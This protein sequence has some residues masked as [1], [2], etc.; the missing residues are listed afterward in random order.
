MKKSFAKLFEARE[1]NFY[2]FEM[3]KAFS[4]IISEIF[5]IFF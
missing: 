3:L 5:E 2:L 1:G 4:D